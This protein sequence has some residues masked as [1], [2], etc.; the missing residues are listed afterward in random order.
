MDEMLKTRMN[1]YLSKKWKDMQ[2]SMWEME[3]D[4]EEGMSDMDSFIE[5]MKSQPRYNPIEIIR[6]LLD[7]IVK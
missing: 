3:D 2:L 6:R 1:N 4:M 7:E 5:D